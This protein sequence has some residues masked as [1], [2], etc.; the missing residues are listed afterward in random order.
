MTASTKKIVK[1][2]SSIIGMKDILPDEQLKDKGVNSL[3][4]LLI[5]ASIEEQFNIKIPDSE[6]KM[7]N[8]ETVREIDEML[9][10]IEK[11]Q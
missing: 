11:G 10:R 2:I 3:N 1:I 8:F 6:M 7:S 9:K 4:M 5:L